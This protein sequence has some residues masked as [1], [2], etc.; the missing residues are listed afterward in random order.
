M[1]DGILTGIL[2]AIPILGVLFELLGGSGISERHHS[3][4]D[5]YQIVSSLS[6]ALV[7]A[8]VFMGVTGLLLSWL[9]NVGVF[10]MDTT[11]TLGF[12]AAFLVVLFAIWLCLRRYRVVTYDACMIVTPFMGKSVTVRYRD[13]DRMEWT[14]IRTGTGY[15]NL[16]VFVDGKRVAMLWGVLDL[17]QILLRIDR[18]DVLASQ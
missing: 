8:M 4:H 14:G 7:V 16:N 12:F 11:V 6:S 5:T 1:A 3:H 15:R 18:F 17:E 9:C 10:N 13:I 2:I